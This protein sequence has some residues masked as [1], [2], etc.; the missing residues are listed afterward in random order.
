MN[1]RAFF[2][3]W[4]Y[5][6][7]EGSASHSGRASAQRLC[8]DDTC[9]L[10]VARAGV[11]RDY[12]IA[13][14]LPAFNATHVWFD[15]YISPTVAPP[16]FTPTSG[17]PG[18]CR[19]SRLVRGIPIL[20][21]AISSAVAG[22][23][24]ACARHRV[25][26]HVLLLP[27]CVLQGGVHETAKLRGGRRAVGYRGERALLLFQNLHLHALWRS[28]STG[29]L[30]VGR[31]GGVL[32]GRPLRY[33]RRHGRDGSERYVVDRTPSAVIRGGI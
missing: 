21:A 25:P 22:V 7:N 23:L 33:R 15:P 6:Q 9:G 4:V 3:R 10:L 28:V 2:D 18:Q 20:V 17:A 12:L 13:L 16:F 5:H 27:R 14:R 26:A 30:V 32:Q 11:R 1:L 24:R 29:V 8:T 19:R 31:T